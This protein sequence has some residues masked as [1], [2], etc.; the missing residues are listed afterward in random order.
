[1]E[2]DAISIKVEAQNVAE[3]KELTLRSYALVWGALV[4]LLIATVSLS[5]LNLGRWAVY[6]SL[7]IASV[8]AALVFWYFMHLCSETL[9]VIKL[10]V[11]IVFILLAVF[12]GLT[13]SDVLTR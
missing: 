3:P 13:F 12:I 6:I 1:M 7:G 9:R 5:A 4:V 2:S 11:P 10:I 8:Q